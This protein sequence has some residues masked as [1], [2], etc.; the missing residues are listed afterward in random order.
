MGS[1]APHPTPQAK[2][3][4]L[5]LRGESTRGHVP[6][7]RRQQNTQDQVS[8]SA[9]DLL[10]LLLAPRTETVAHQWAMLNSCRRTRTGIDPALF[11][12][13]TKRDSHTKCVLGAWKTL[14]EPHGKLKQPTK[15][16]KGAGIYVYRWRIST[17]LT[18][19]SPGNGTHQAKR[20]ELALVALSALGGV[21]RHEEYPANA[22]TE[23]SKN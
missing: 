21:V 11:R 5:D 4:V 15:A 14:I 17:R 7:P 3:V 6:H 10:P 18:I 13:A 8:K 16:N 23:T 12:V 2:R 19:I 1:G 20:V 9:L 22:R